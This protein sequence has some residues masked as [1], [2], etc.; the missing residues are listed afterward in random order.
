[1]NETTY[2]LLSFSLKACLAA[3]PGIGGFLS[4]VISE[5]EAINKDNKF[6]KVTQEI[7]SVLKRD[8]KSYPPLRAEYMSDEYMNVSII[9]DRP[10]AWIKEK[11]ENV[12]LNLSEKTFHAGTYLYAINHLYMKHNRKIGAD[13]KEYILNYIYGL[14]CE[15]ESALFL[16]EKLV[17]DYYFNLSRFIN[18]ICNEPKIG[19]FYAIK[20]LENASGIHNKYSVFGGAV[21]VCN[22]FAFANEINSLIDPTAK[23]NIM[24]AHIDELR[25]LIFKI[26]NTEEPVIDKRTDVQI[27]GGFLDQ[28][29]S[30]AYLIISTLLNLYQC[31]SAIG[32]L[33]C[34]A[35]YKGIC[36]RYLGE[37]PKDMHDSW[38][39]LD[40]LRRYCQLSQSTN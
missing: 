31:Y 34:I 33:D 21:A 11:L 1:M 30:K 19:L 12:N 22:E 23:I 5:F 9:M 25:D 3:I 36:E 18:Y 20:S 13:D 38:K 32:K 26:D 6:K 40:V 37:L 17:V 29:G 2:K 4:L 14:N 16:S 39:E 28:F 10:T 27:S 35:E 8:V 15:I 7:I 24:N